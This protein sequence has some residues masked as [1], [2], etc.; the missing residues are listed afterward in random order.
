MSPLLNQTKG[1][2]A[3][4]NGQPYVMV[5]HVHLARNV[6]FGVLNVVTFPTKAI[7]VVEIQPMRSTYLGVRLI[8]P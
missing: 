5:V 8:S 6:D 3:L 7:K 4:S 2:R 1:F